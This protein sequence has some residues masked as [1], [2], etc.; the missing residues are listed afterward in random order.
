VSR[1]NSPV[2]R[3]LSDPTQKFTLFAPTNDALQ[4]MADDWNAKTPD[5][6]RDMVVYH[7]LPQIVRAADLVDFQ[8]PTTLMANAAAY[9]KKGSG[10]NVKITN[11]ADS[12]DDVADVETGGETTAAG[13]GGPRVVRVGNVSGGVTAKLVRGDIAASNGQLHVIDR[14][15]L[16]P[17]STSTV[18]QENGLRVF[19]ESMGA[20]Q[21]LAA[22]ESISD[23][24]VF[25]PTD[26]AF[27]AAAEQ[28]LNGLDSDLFYQVGF[29]HASVLSTFFVVSI[30]VRF[31]CICV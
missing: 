5:E 17:G 22:I 9:Q 30:C 31:V 14:V 13:G 4:T 23:I 7:V 11:F 19:Y 29:D 12:S 24:T 21:L 10:Q 1:V 27:R 20:A 3:S 8:F 2:V 26:A 6:L 25:A 28:G 16:P 15:L 18:L